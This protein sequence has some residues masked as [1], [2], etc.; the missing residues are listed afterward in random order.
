MMKVL[1]HLT[2]L[3]CAVALTNPGC[4]GAQD[5]T[6]PQEAEVA[7]A[8]PATDAAGSIDWEKE[9]GVEKKVPD[10][11]TGELPVAP[12]ETSPANAGAKPFQH[13]NMAQAF[14][15]QAGIR[16]IVN[17]FVE[18]NT[19]DPRIDA[20]FRNQD[21]V[22]LRR[23][24]FEQFCYLLDAGCAYTG[25]DMKSAHKDL[26]VTRADL[27]ALVENLQKAMREAEVPFAAQNRFLAKLAPMDKDV[28]TR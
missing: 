18:L 26:G 12:Y 21:I 13:S 3:A 22:R 5:M 25:R 19:T 7:K 4:A 27:N 23:T 11:V 20:I 28:V 14:G 16:A 9:F 10:P 15:G 24:L 2:P 8:D 1:K 17:R 6:G